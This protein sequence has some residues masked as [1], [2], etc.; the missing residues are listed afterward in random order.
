[1]AKS[2]DEMSKEEL[3]E[4]LEDLDSEIYA[5]QGKIATASKRISR[6]SKLRENILDLLAASSMR[7]GWKH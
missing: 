3:A 5:D 6:H 7:R 4:V 1:M 2:L